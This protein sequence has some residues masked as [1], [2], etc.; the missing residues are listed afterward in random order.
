MG[1]LRAYLGVLIYMSLCPLS[2]RAAYW[3]ID[4]H[5]PIHEAV[6]MH[7][8]RNRFD[9]LEACLYI[10]D[11]DVNGNCFSKLEPL[12]GHLLSMTTTLWTLGSR[13]AVDEFM[14]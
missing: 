9:E 6:R 5:K 2:K 14:T 11:P 3:N 4:L 13:L 10:S 8:Y 12:N 7:I 1:K